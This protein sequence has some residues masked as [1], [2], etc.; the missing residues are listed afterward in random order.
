V[1]KHAAVPN[2]STRYERAKRA[3]RHCIGA[4]PLPHEG[5]PTTNYIITITLD[6]SPETD[7]HLQ[8]PQGIEDEVRSWLTALRA[9]VQTVTV[10]ERS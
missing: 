3:A 7:E 2:P 10:E 6:V 9:V 8:T 4:P 5:H 1:R